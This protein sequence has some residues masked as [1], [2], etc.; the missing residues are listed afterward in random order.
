MRAKIT[1]FL[2]IFLLLSVALAACSSGGGEVPICNPEAEAQEPTWEEKET[3]WAE[4]GW[5]RATTL[6]EASEVAGFE[7]VSFG[8][9]PEGFCRSLHISV[10]DRCIP[11]SEI[12]EDCDMPVWVTQYWSWLGNES[13]EP[14]EHAILVLTQSPGNIGTGDKPTEVGDYPATV[15]R[16]GGETVVLYWEIDGMNFMLAGMLH[17]PLTEELI[18]QVAASIEMD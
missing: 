18:Y 7:V 2:A 8:F 16:D 11:L 1:C 9:I 17:E 13:L 10:E 5:W 15:D 14:S 6:E 12:I 4:N 3:H